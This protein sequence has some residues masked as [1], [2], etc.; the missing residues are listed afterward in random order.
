MDSMAEVAEALVKSASSSD[1]E[2][3]LFCFKLG[4]DLQ[5]SLREELQKV[6]DFTRVMSRDDLDDNKHSIIE[7]FIECEGFHD[8]KG[9]R[10]GRLSAP[11]ACAVL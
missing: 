10:G 6:D 4:F 11:F 7:H 1:S 2:E 8:I 5:T 3:K 9:D